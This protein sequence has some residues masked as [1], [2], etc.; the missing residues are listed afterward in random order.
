MAIYLTQLSSN[1][2]DFPPVQSALTEPDGL[3]A[4]GGD[5]SP[6]RLLNAYR[7]GIFPWYSPGEP[8]LWWSPSVRAAFDPH[9]YRPAKSLRKFQRNHAYD[10][11]INYA[12]ADV[13]R[14][15]ADTRPPEQTWINPEMQQAY[16]ELANQGYCHSVEVWHHE[17]LVGGFYGIGIGQ[18]F[19]GESMFSI[20]TN[21][22]K[23]ALWHFCDHFS[24]HD[25]QM[26]D[27]Q[28]MNPHLQSLGAFSL[29]R[30]DFLQRLLCLK[31][32]SVKTGCFSPQWLTRN[33]A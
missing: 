31:Q 12:T 24:Q 9:H 8:I 33:H 23:I 4:F 15:C 32:K 25:G 27:C 19:C 3:L 29:P 7:H 6:Q 20:E 21:A 16:I 10:V 18:L 5:L 22:S 26:I 17:R 14:S 28:L 1:S 13:I 11:S 2:L 30:E